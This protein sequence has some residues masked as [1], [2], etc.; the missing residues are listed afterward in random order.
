GYVEFGAMGRKKRGK[1]VV[2]MIGCRGECEIEKQGD[3]QIVSEKELP[4]VSLAWQLLA[5]VS[6][7]GDR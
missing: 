2:D 6:D 4:G 1:G 7:S 5:I 3:D